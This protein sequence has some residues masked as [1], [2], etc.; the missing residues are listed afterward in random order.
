MGDHSTINQVSHPESYISQTGAVHDYKQ[1][2]SYVFQQNTIEQLQQNTI[3]IHNR[4]YYPIKSNSLFGVTY[5]SEGTA[6]KMVVTDIDTLRSGSKSVINATVITDEG[7]HTQTL[8]KENIQHV[9]PDPKIQKYISFTTE[10]KTQTAAKIEEYAG[11]HPKLVPLPVVAMLILE[12]DEKTHRHIAAAVHQLTPER[13]S[14]LKHYVHSLTHLLTGSTNPHVLRNT[15]STLTEIAK[16]HPEDVKVADTALN[17][18]I[19]H[20]DKEIRS[21]ALH[22]IALIIT[23][24]QHVP[25]GCIENCVERLHSNAEENKYAAQIIAETAQLSPVRTRDTVPLL[26][27]ALTDFDDHHNQIAVLSALARI[28]DTYPQTVMPYIDTIVGLTNKTGDD[29]VR[30]NIASVIY[31]VAQQ[32]PEIAVNNVDAVDGLLTSSN[33]YAVLNATGVFAQISQ[34]APDLASKYTFELLT[35][36]SNATPTHEEIHLNACVALRNIPISSEARDAVSDAVSDVYYE[37]SSEPVKTAANEV[38]THWQ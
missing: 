5:H 13:V 35:A 8:S 10:S 16:S 30:A 27:E 2:E 12:G 29:N 38:L 3:K 31:N 21:T 26:M 22:A 24:T 25:D 17:D 23:E 6:E 18:L 7:K 14:E 11:Y 33:L 4:E 1:I 15:V 34:Q 37:T 9:T 36:L 20:S 32:N 19:T 28:A